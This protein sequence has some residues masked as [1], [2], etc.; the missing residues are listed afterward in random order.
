MAGCER[1]YLCTVCGQEVEDLAESDLYLRYV[2]GE[3]EWDLLHQFP[4]RHIQC[5]PV[6]AQFIVD[7][8]FVPL[9]VEGA[10]S[11]ENLDPEFVRGEEQRV[12]QA[13]RRL[14]ELP[15]ANVPI[16]EYPLPEVLARR[17][18]A[19]FESQP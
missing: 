8:T 1:G 3:V 11:K 7:E 12:T 14:R 6:L 2:L 10:F 19:S 16:S 9:V 15:T 5:N 13:Y 17:K 4:E 18:T